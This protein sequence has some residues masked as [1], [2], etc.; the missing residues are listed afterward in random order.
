MSVE[1]LRAG[2]S[3]L[4]EGIKDRRDRKAAKEK[5]KKE[6]EDQVKKE[7]SQQALAD[8]ID[9]SL[10]GQTLQ[11]QFLSSGVR[12]GSIDPEKAATAL[13]DLQGKKLFY[14]LQSRVITEKD[15]VTKK[16]LM[17]VLN[18]ATA[19]YNRVNGIEA[20]NIAKEQMIGVLEA[21]KMFGVLNKGGGKG[22][23][24]NSSAGGAENPASLE[25]TY[26]D[27]ADYVTDSWIKDPFVMDYMPG[28]KRTQGFYNADLSADDAEFMQ[29]QQR[30]ENN[31]DHYLSQHPILGKKGMEVYRAKERQR[32]VQIL[33]REGL[34]GVS[35]L[36]TSGDKIENKNLTATIPM[37]QELAISIAQQNKGIVKKTK[38]GE[39]KESR[40]FSG[41]M[42]LVPE[43]KAKKSTTSSQGGSVTPADN[44]YLE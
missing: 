32:I 22:G 35:R 16:K 38:K 21:K 31:V 44:Y 1:N 39:L 3:D 36:G 41:K 42:P 14:Q 10:P 13:G 30:V 33:G 8:T 34:N 9:S 11:G 24:G 2:L 40:V 4:R 20:Y 27:L 26:D 19:A 28:A 5:A 12:G 6:A 25:V 7:A 18:N 17:E 43:P 15:P 29:F 37:S 23:G